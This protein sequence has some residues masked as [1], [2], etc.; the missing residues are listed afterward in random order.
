MLLI[1]NTIDLKIKNEKMLDAMI[2]TKIQ[3]A[4]YEL[5]K[6]QQKRQK[7]HKFCLSLNMQ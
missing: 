4:G 2:I 5:P 3:S 1:E 7:P 6:H